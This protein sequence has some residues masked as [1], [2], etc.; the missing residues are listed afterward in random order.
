MI[1]FIGLVFVSISIILI[2]PYEPIGKLL[3]VETNIYLV[4]IMMALLG[5][6]M[7][8]LFI[9]C[10]PDLIDIIKDIYPNSLD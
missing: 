2:G 7:A 8:Y 3:G 10:L 4:V 6:H 5:F 9:A 1:I